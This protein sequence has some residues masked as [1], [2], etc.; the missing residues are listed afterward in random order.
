MQ[1]DAMVGR[2][3]D[4]DQSTLAEH[5]Q[6]SSLSSRVLRDIPLYPVAQVSDIPHRRS[7]AGHANP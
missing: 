6:F 5:A 7:R 4:G 3:I 2:S 1:R